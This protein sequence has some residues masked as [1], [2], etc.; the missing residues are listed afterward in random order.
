MNELK[1]ADKTVKEIQ[2]RAEDIVSD[3]QS[4]GDEIMNK[5]QHVLNQQ[6]S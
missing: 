1:K 6:K 5:I 3:M 2:N 4:K